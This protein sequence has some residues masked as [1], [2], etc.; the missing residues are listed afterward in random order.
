M[1][2][3]NCVQLFLHRPIRKLL[4]PINQSSYLIC[5]CFILLT[6]LKKQICMKK[7]MR[8]VLSQILTCF[9]FVVLFSKYY[10]FVKKVTL[11]KKSYI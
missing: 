2:D 8:R 6:E 9:I 1:I 5:F 11:Q 4:V 7:K 3:R 10:G